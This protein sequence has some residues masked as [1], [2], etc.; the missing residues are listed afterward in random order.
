[1]AYA[2]VHAW[3]NAGATLPAIIEFQSF[4]Q[5][6]SFL[7]KIYIEAK[8]MMLL[9]KRCDQII[10]CQMVSHKTNNICIHRQNMMTVERQGGT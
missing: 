9:E 4:H 10:K 6:T 7:G 5:V 2:Y 1:M 8:S 3:K